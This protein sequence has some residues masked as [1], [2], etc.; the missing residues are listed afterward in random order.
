MK[1]MK[2]NKAS[3]SKGIRP[4]V[5]KCCMEQL[6]GVICTIFNVFK[7]CAVTGVGKTY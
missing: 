7:Q 1:R 2:P 5:L 3:G 6:S 4:G